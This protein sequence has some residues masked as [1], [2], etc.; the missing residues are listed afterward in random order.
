LHPLCI[1]AELGEDLEDSKQPADQLKSRPLQV[2]FDIHGPPTS[3]QKFTV[4]TLPSSVYLSTPS[5]PQIHYGVTLLSF[6]ILFDKLVTLQKGTT[7]FYHHIASYSS[8]F[9]YQIAFVSPK[10]GSS[11]LK[12]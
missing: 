12:Y 1:P 3:G 4:Q 7:K 5:A 10:M 11:L 9:L 6:F 2:D 8:A